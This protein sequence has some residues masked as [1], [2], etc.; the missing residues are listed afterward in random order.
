MRELVVFYILFAD[1]ANNFMFSLTFEV[2]PHILLVNLKA[3]GSAKF[4]PQ[5]TFFNNAFDILKKTILTT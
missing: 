1:T 5:S 2:N 4:E 3:G